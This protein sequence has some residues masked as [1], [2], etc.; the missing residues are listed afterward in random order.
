MFEEDEGAADG[1]KVYRLKWDTVRYEL[2]KKETLSCLF[3]RY[4]IRHG[5]MSEFFNLKDEG[6][7]RT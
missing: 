1:Q 4:L 6:A 5:K 7:K 3:V 2:S